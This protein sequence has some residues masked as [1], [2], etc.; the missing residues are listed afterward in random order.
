MI[1]ENSNGVAYIAKDFSSLLSIKGLSDNLLKTHFT[2]YQSYAANTNK[3]LEKLQ[4]IA[5]SGD[6]A[7]PEF[8]EM[9]RRFGWEWNGMR[10]HELYFENLAAQSAPLDNNSLFAKKAAENFGS[11]ENWQ[12]NFRAAGAMRGI[13]WVIAYYDP[14][15]N[16]LINICS[17]GFIWQ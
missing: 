5:K 12:K 6:P 2:L 11:L 10:L 7:T 13:G 3:L 4:E 14:N 16:K 8:A 17:L 15:A 9:K 1:K